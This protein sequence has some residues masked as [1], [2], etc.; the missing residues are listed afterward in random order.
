M[1]SARVEPPCPSFAFGLV[2]SRATQC[3]NPRSSAARRG[4]VR[5]SITMEAS[6]H[7]IRSERETTRPRR[8]SPSHPQKRGTSRKREEPKPENPG[9]CNAKLTMPTRDDSWTV[10]RSNF[11]VWLCFRWRDAGRMLR[12]RRSREEGMES[13][14]VDDNDSILRMTGDTMP[15][16]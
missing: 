5:W 10:S 12:R 2:Q 4:A 9:S 3:S 16:E 6:R 14:D 8:G 11:M 13:V 7:T 15:S 1:E